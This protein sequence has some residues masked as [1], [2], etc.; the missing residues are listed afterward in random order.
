[1]LRGV[2]PLVIT[3]QLLLLLP[4][5]PLLVMSQRTSRA[6][7]SRHQGFVAVAALIGLASIVLALT[8]LALSF[9]ITE[10]VDPLLSLAPPLLTLAA[11]GAVLRRGL[12]AGDLRRRPR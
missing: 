12:W 5:L 7:R 1:M 6:H 11:C 8:S 9:D 4:A 10:S 3:L 2:Y